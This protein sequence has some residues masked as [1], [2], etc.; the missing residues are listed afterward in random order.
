[1]LAI[2]LAERALIAESRV[3]EMAAQIETIRGKEIP[4]ESTMQAN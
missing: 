2:D 3:D 1:M 4:N